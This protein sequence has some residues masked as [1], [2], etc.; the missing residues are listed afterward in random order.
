MSPYKR[1]DDPP[2]MQEHNYTRKS[3]T[4]TFEVLTDRIHEHKIDCNEEINK[5]LTDLMKNT[6]SWKVAC[7]F[8]CSA[9]I[10]V[11]AGVW[12]IR[13]AIENVRDSIPIE[14]IS[15]NTAFTADKIKT[16]EESLKPKNDSIELEMVQKVVKRLDLKKIK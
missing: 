6:I 8:F 4:V 10:V 1:H 14:K 5:K 7:Y 16:I 3:D 15:N 13:D 11:G 9:L 12:A 2:D